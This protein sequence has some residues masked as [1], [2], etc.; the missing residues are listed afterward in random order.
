[1]RVHL[2]RGMVMFETSVASIRTAESLLSIS[3]VAS[4]GDPRDNNLANS[5]ATITTMHPLFG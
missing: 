4:Y 1:M 3:F 5:S 2:S